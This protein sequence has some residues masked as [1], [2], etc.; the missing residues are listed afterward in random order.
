MDLE[1]SNNGWLRII[2]PS[3]QSQ[4]TICVCVSVHRCQQSLLCK[5]KKALTL[6][7]ADRDLRRKHPRAQRAK[8]ILAPTHRTGDRAAFAPLSTNSSAVRPAI[9]KF[10]ACSEFILYRGVVCT[11]RER[12]PTHRMASHNP[13]CRPLPCRSHAGGRGSRSRPADNR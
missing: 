9:Q 10:L 7:L 4:M 2:L 3:L 11:S 13:D 5:T 6:R 12:V 1:V 8:Q